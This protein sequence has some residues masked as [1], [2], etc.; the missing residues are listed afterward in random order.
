MVGNA[1]CNVIENKVFA[2]N[3][4]NELSRCSYQQLEE[5]SD[6]FSV[7]KTIYEG[8]ARNGET[9]RFYGK[10][11]TVA[12]K[13]TQFFTGLSRLRNAATLLSLLAYC[14]Q[15]QHSSESSNTIRTFLSDREKAA[16][17]FLGGYVLHNLHKKHARSNSVE[18]QQAMA[19]LKARKLESMTNSERKLVSALTRGGLVNNSACVT[20]FLQSRMLF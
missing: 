3:M 15:K 16:L 14:E 20:D 13:S 18:R 10:Y 2:V 12:V 4:R 8:Y 6:E 1:V 17:H 5:E 11:A 7:V 9:E 19:I